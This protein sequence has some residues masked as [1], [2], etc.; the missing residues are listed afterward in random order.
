MLPQVEYTFYQENHGAMQS[1]S[2][3]ALAGSRAFRRAK[4]AT[5]LVDPEFSVRKD[6]TAVPASRPNAIEFPKSVKQQA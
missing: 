6:C 5:G 1:G 3:P 4:A 2:L